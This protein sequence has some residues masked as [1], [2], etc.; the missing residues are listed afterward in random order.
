MT[1]G[2]RGV[3]VSLGQTCQVA[4]TLV[5]TLTCRVRPEGVH[6][7]TV[8]LELVAHEG[9]AFN[10]VNAATAVYQAARKLPYAR[11]EA[12]KGKAAP[13]GPVAQHP[14]FQHLLGLLVQHVEHFTSRWP[15][16]PPEL[17]LMEGRSCTAKLAGPLQVTHT[18]SVP[19]SCWVLAIVSPCTP[20]LTSPVLARE[21]ANVLLA[22][23]TLETA[24]PEHLLLQL[25]RPARKVP[26]TFP[27]QEASNALWGLGKLFAQAPELMPAQVAKAVQASSPQTPCKLLPPPPSSSAAQ[28]ARSRMHGIT[29]PVL[30]GKQPCISAA[31]VGCQHACA[32]PG[33]CTE[34]FMDRRGSCSS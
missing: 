12:S 29:L 14:G 6:V 33:G 27:P 30:A 20:S 16:S 23:G 13:R 32:L 2:T 5:I 31:G 19:C 11:I 21:T 34:P 15:P 3:A 8:I 4:D 25:V 22:F 28:L 9:A 24:P 18:G 17:C 7:C 10:A 26:G 1:D